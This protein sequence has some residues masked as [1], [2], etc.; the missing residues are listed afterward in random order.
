M[1]EISIEILPDGSLKVTTSKV[2]GPNH[3]NAESFLNEM[4]RLS[5]GTPKRTKRID[6]NRKLTCNHDHDHHDHIHTDGGHGHS[7]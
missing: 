2:S 6:V 5:G 7:H 1:D 3:I 4:S